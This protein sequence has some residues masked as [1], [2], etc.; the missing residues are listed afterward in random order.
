MW[1]NP[2]TGAPEY[3]VDNMG[4]AYYW[5]CVMCGTQVV[6]ETLCDC[7]FTY[8]ENCEELGIENALV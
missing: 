1:H 8:A 5:N 6:E 7:G 2:W 4:P 3:D